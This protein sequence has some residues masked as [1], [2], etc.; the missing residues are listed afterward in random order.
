[1]MQVFVGHI[2]GVLILSYVF[3]DVLFLLFLFLQVYF[4]AH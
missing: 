2:L 4:C 3:L 1:M